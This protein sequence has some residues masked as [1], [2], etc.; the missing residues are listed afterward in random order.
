MLGC[1][2]MVALFSDLQGPAAKA[3][4]LK[5]RRQKFLKLKNPM[6]IRFFRWI[7]GVWALLVLKVDKEEAGSGAA[8]PAKF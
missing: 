5:R 4:A 1:S 8:A 3:P 6:K 7:A 2:E